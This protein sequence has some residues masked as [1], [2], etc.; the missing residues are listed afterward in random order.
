MA[1]SP[2]MFD[3][4]A[5]NVICMYV[6]IS[7]HGLTRRIC[8]MLYVVFDRSVHLTMAEVPFLDKLE[9]VTRLS[10]SKGLAPVTNIVSPPLKDSAGYLL[11]YDVWSLIII[12]LFDQ[13]ICNP[14]K[15][16]EVHCHFR[17]S[18]LFH[19]LHCFLFYL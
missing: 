8:R 3:G 5:V 11:S 4:T 1:S 19:F 7:Q 18:G 10:R 16:C 17:A 13:G 9:I 12:I 15:D 2:D 14:G 6:H